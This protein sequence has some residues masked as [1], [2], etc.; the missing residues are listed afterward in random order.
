MN[1]PDVS[2]SLLIT[3]KRAVYD[4]CPSALVSH[5]DGNPAAEMRIVSRMPHARSCCIT[6][7]GSKLGGGH[8][9]SVAS[10]RRGQAPRDEDSHKS[11]F[12]MVGLDAAHVVRTRRI[13][14]VHQRVK[15][16]SKLSEIKAFSD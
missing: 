5:R 15:G 14:G 6:V 8:K 2:W 3:G 10:W 4:M 16:A 13:Q 11:S 7:R 1:G 12:V 9:E